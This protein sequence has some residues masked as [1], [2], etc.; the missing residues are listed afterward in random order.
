MPGFGL[1]PRTI[2]QLQPYR[3]PF[4]QGDVVSHPWAR[5]FNWVYTTLLSLLGGTPRT[6]QA[7]LAAIAGTLGSQDTG[8]LINVT[9]FNHVL[10]WDGA[11]WT[12]GPG[13]NG[14][15]YAV[16]FGIPPTVNGWHMEDGTLAVPY[17]KG[18]GTTG[19][20]DLPVSAG[21]YFRQ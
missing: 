21:N 6:T 4:L 3:T 12:W 13:E 19:T 1:T 18:D 5:F 20:V 17:L 15:G 9:D 7:G 11:Q 8:L 2:A 10:E 14:S 16:L